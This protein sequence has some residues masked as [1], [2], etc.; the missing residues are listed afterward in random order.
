MESSNE[1]VCTKKEKDHCISYNFIKYW[2]LS[3]TFLE[4]D[5]ACFWFLSFRAKTGVSILLGA[6]LKVYTLG[7]KVTAFLNILCS[8]PSLEKT[9][10]SFSQARCLLEKLKEIGSVLLWHSKF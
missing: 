9:E 7:K 6:F 10:E 8:T 1:L 5:H 4:R 3:V 2:S